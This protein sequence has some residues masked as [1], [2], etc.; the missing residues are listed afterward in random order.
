MFDIHEILG[1]IAGILALGSFLTYYY[2]ILNGKASP[3]RVTWFI[4]TLVGI[5]IAASYY[6]IG[7]RDTI[8][9]PIG[10]VI[11]PF[12]TFILS[13]KYG[14]GGYTLLDQSCIVLVLLSLVVWYISGS[15]ILTLII[16]IFI[17]FVGII[18]TVIKSYVRP[19]SEYLPSWILTFVVSIIN[20]LAVSEWEFSI[21]IYPIYMI[22]FNGLILFFLLLPILSNRIKAF[23]V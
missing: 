3:S 13:I 19:E 23:F 1:V 22:V 6:S 5:M 15:A 18:P 20:I 8:W 4:L 11:G 7:A 10:Y 21:Y 16:S 2:A 9:V 17:D 12:I 14:E